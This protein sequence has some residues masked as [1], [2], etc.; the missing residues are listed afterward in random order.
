MAFQY[1]LFFAVL[2]N[3]YHYIGTKVS[4]PLSVYNEHLTQAQT[5]ALS[6]INIVRYHSYLILPGWFGGL[7]YSSN[8]SQ[9]RPNNH[10]LDLVCLM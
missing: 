10:D 4:C 3:H 8:N 1:H 2:P 7:K 9:I 5:S 6:L